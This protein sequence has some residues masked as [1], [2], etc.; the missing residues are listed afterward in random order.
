[1]FK[2]I[3]TIIVF[4]T[5]SMMVSAHP[6]GQDKQGGHFNRSTGEYHCHRA[7]CVATQN[8]VKQATREAQDEGRAFSAMYDRKDWKHWSDFD[9]DC[10]NTRHEIL[11]DQAVG[12]VRLSPDG[13]YVSTGLWDDPYSG[14]KYTRASDLDIDHVVP[15]F[16]AHKHGGANWP[17]QLKEQYANDPEGL[18]AVDDGLNQQKSAKGPDEWMPPNKAYHCGYIAHFDRIVAKYRLQYTPSEQQF[19]AAARSRCRH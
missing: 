14:K 19:M 7:G 16:W 17:V 10:M 12:P 5:L 18:L 8:Q 4:S 13:C 11:K 15:L 2:N 6:G 1:M 3:T 9:S